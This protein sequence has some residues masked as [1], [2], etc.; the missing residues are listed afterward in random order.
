MVVFDRTAAVI[1]ILTIAP[2]VL[3]M[4]E[5]LSRTV[6]K[7]RLICLKRQLSVRGVLI[8]LS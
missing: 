6:D 7:R 1:L 2:A 8:P 5:L 4:T 3:I